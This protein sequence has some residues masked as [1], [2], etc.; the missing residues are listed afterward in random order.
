LSLLTSNIKREICGVLNGVL[1]FFKKYEKN[2]ALSILSFMLDPRFKSLRLVSF[3]IGQKHVISIM[4]KYDQILNFFSFIMLP[5]LAWRT[6]KLFDGL[7]YE[8]KGEDNERRR[9]WGVLLG[10]LHF[11]GS[12]ACWSS[13]VGARKINKQ[14]NYSHGLAQN[15]QQV[16]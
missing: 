7:N 5:H 14:L 4:E 6:P 11:E 3:L 2:K 1:F 15:K 10:S 12:G 9:S 13:R 16:G 8:S